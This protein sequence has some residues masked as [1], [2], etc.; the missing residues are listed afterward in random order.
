MPLVR[1]ATLAPLASTSVTLNEFLLSVRPAL[2]SSYTAYV[3]SLMSFEP[4]TVFL[5]LK[6]TV[7]P[8]DTSV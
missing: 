2:I 1:S 6:F 4:A 5:S 3:V 7:S 8:S